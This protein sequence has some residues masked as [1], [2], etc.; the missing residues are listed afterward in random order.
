VIAVDVDVAIDTNHNYVDIHDDGFVVVVLVVVVVALEVNYD[1][2]VQCSICGRQGHN[3]R[4]C[5]RR[6]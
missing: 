6:H 1:R 4:S 5:A 2:Q 3:R